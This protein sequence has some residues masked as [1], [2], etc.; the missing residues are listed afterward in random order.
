M[1][2]S[3]K[4]S[5]DLILLITNIYIMLTIYKALYKHHFTRLFQQILGW[6]IFF[7]FFRELRLT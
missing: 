7:F 6:I 1:I 3:V 5:Y 4:S 2:L